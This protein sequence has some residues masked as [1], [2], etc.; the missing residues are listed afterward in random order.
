MPWEV[1]SAQSTSRWENGNGSSDEA[2]N[3][4]KVFIL[5][6]PSRASSVALQEVSLL[7]SSLKP[8]QTASSHAAK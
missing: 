1:C 7:R 6:H 3:M 5:L 4:M 2:R 8:L